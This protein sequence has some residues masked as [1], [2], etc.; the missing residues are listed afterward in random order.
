MM[1]RGFFYWSKLTLCDNNKNVKA[2]SLIVELKIK[3]GPS[4]I[5]YNIDI[6]V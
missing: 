6:F 4:L 5:I 1:I 2:F 3:P